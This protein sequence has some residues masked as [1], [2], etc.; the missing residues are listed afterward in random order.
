MNL[1]TEMNHGGHGEHGVQ[2]ADGLGFVKPHKV[3]GEASQKVIPH[4]AF[5]ILYIPLSVLSVTSVVNSNF[6]F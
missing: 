1:K 5:T 2:T 3:K 6:P 4:R